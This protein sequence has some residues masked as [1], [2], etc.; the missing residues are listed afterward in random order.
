MANGTHTQDALKQYL[1]GISRYP[2]LTRPEEISLAK[3]VA[4]GDPA[5]RERMIQ[6]NLRLV[7]TV[8]KPYCGRG[9][10][11]VDLIQEGTVGLMQAVDRYDWRREARFST[12]AGW[13]IRNAILQALATTGRAIRLPESMLERITLVRRADAALTAGLGRT[14]TDDEIAAELGLTTAQVFQALS[15][16]QP[17]S[18][19]DALAGTD[20]E[21]SVGDT[22]ADPVAVDPLRPLVDDVSSTAL[23]E[24]LAA[25]P[26]R[27]RRVLEP[28][29]GLADGVARTVE[30][31]AEELGVTRERVRQIELGAL[32]KL[33]PVARVAGMAEAA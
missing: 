2:L 10:E 8:A 4:A 1:T 32:R 22:I 12:Y 19:L 23:A 33:E 25:L 26:E 16:A 31:V 30:A 11:L 24:T 6:S 27:G 17:V 21:L 9:L 3:R 20:G 29:F 14:P 28:R 15:A 7:V 18:S 13:W 5:A